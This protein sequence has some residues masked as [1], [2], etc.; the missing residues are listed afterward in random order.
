MSADTCV[1]VSF[2]DERDDGELVRL[3]RQLRSGDAGAAF[4]LRVVVNSPRGEALRLPDD[5]ASVNTTVRQNTGFNIGAWNHGWLNNPGYA[6]YVFLQDECEIVR[7]GWLARYRKLLSEPGVGA[8][9]ES[10]LIWPGWRRFARQWPEATAECAAIAR[11]RA[12]A[13][14]K[15]PSHLQTLAIGASAACLEATGGFL[16][17]DGKAQAIATEIMFSRL[18]LARGFAIRQSA[19]RPFEYIMHPQWRSLRDDSA[20]VS[21]NVNR[22]LKRFFGQPFR[23][24]APARE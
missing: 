1:I 9:G 5:L 2:Y 13:L 11:Q 18:C 8:A 15:S 4:D 19:W 21:W 10:L 12:I 3:L 24:P 20:K 16:L 14:G 17:A 22:A 6:F 7:T 23:T